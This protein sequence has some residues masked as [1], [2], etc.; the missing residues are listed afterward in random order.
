MRDHHR[1]EFFCSRASW[2]QLVPTAS[3]DHRYGIITATANRS[4][5]V[6]P[7]T[8]TE[9][10]V[11]SHTLSDPADPYEPNASQTRDGAHI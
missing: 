8:E 2:S 1:G 5:K 11:L 7:T 3:C 4:W 6:Q 10:H 9:P